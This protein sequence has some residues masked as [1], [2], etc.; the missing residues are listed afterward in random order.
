MTTLS[1]SPLHFVKGFDDYISSASAHDQDRPG[2]ASA[3][4][5]HMSCVGDCAPETFVGDV[6]RTALSF[7]KGDLDVDAYSYVLS[8]AH[9]E[10]DPADDA[11]GAVAHGL[12]RE[13]LKE[14]FPGRQAKIVTQR[15][16]GRWEAL[17]GQRTWVDGHW[18]SHVVVANV[19]EQAVELTWADA[20]GVE[21]T[22][23]YKPGRAIDGD[24]KNIFRL[25]HITDEVVMRQWKYDNA[26]YVEACRQ[27]SEGAAAK[28]DF[29]ERAERGYSSYDEVRLKLRTAAAQST[30]WDDF[31]TRCQAA[32]V[33]VKT[34]G[35]GG[36]GVSYAW[37]DDSGMERKARA[38]GKTGI[39]QEFARAEVE[40]RCAE[41]VAALER[42]ETLEVPEQVLVV[43][44]TT[45]A[46]DRPRPVYLTDD[47]K[48]P[49]AN[50]QTLAE[51][52]WKVQATGGTYEGR[53]EQ[54]LATGEDVEG[55][56]LEREDDRVV[57]TVDT[58]DGAV[59][60]DVDEALAARVLEV[61]A[62]QAQA[63]GRLAE[64]DALMNEAE[65]VRARADAV[66]REA[67][68]E[69]EAASTARRDGYNAGH[70]EGLAEVEE[71]KKDAETAVEEGRRRGYD[72]GREEGV[73]S[74][75]GLYDLK[76]RRLADREAA[77]EKWETETEPK[78]RAAIRTEVED[79]ARA[80]RDAAAQ[81]RRDAAD[82]LESAQADRTAA[83]EKLHE[84]AGLTPEQAADRV[85]DD[86][87]WK[88]K[89]ALERYPVVSVAYD[90]DGKPR[91]VVGDDGKPVVTNAWSQMKVDVAHDRSPGGD[92][93]V[94]QARRNGRAMRKSLEKEVG[95]FGGVQGQTK[96]QK[97]E[98]FGK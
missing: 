58:G 15:D 74:A 21:K 67:E 32:A 72:A 3:R 41:N 60:F 45:V 6:R 52:E 37:V 30:S 83:A 69:R 75:R 36:T 25:R 28:M 70:A 97:K 63:E 82:E 31:V 90:E 59:V 24:L 55:V 64:A 88:A 96:G 80:D 9:E 27:H 8:H 71:L 47:G 50:E 61:E 35:K 89:K 49:W 20:K 68:S 26:A 79:A 22:K 4:V 16:N 78:L 12:A 57:A 29:A 54:A 5:E 93:T 73:E 86:F 84:V 34:R 2:G 7:G 23:S 44:S 10:L 42:G 53:A 13:W 87:Q 76:V 51:Y 48:P 18:H 66:L 40:Q 33:D 62:M 98:G 17:G 77:V 46:P 1:G 94:G 85:R 56:E 43:P 91:K 11:L 39:G 81:A 14:A 92:V 38:R 19:A 65:I 95:Q